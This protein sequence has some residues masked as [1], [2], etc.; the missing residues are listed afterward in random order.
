MKQEIRINKYLSDK[1]ICSRREADRLIKKGMVLV[2]GKRAQIGQKVS[3]DDKIELKGGTNNIKKK[4]KYYLYHKP[5]GIVSHKTAKWQTEAREA[6]KL[7]K[8]F[9]PVG[10]LDRAS[11]GLMLLTND[12]RIV[13]RLLNPDF[14]H[15]KEYIV[16]SDKNFKDRDLRK[17]EK[18]VEI[19]GY[20]TKKAKAERISARKIRIILKEGKKHQIRRMLAALGYTTKSL[21][22]VRIANLKLGALKEGEKR[23]LKDKER[24]DLLMSLDLL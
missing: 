2:N 19:E 6:A 16:E 7:P 14:E 23:E 15:E 8:D 12:G 20:R 11:S 5:V 22:R 9:A 18:G 21:Q 1:K 13:N 4:Y 24:K 3:A 10:R 17:I